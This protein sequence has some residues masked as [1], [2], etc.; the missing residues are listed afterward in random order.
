VQEQRVANEQK[1]FERGRSTTFLLLTA[2][3][4]LDDATLSVYRLVMEEMLIAA[5]A[6]LFNTQPLNQED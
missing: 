6:E 4:D 1:R 3:N 2:E 5:Q